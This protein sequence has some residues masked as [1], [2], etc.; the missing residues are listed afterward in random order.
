MGDNLDKTWTTGMPYLWGKH[1]D[2]ERRPNHP[3]TTQIP[4]E[5]ILNHT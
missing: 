1:N 5:L 3:S 4:N 2:D